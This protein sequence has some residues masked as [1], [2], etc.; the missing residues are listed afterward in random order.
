[1]PAIAEQP[2]MRGYLKLLERFPLKTIGNDAE[3]EK[4]VKVIQDL[5][6]TKLDKGEGNY[7]DAL[8][9]LVNLYEDEIH[10]M[11]ED[12]TPQETVTALMAANA[13]SQADMGRIIGSESALSMFLKGERQLSKRHIKKLVQRFK[14]DAAIFL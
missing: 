4:A 2:K 13:M 1:M 12:M 10:V 7:L 5:M 14:V 6:G 11:D 9:A 3:H 8:I